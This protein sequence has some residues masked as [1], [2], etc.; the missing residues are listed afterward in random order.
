MSK[1][2]VLCLLS[3]SVILDSAVLSSKF[4]TSV[5]Q[6][7]DVEGSEHTDNSIQFEHTDNFEAARAL[8]GGSEGEGAAA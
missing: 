7:G 2:A 3:G 4:W 6:M 8:H 1:V 5:E